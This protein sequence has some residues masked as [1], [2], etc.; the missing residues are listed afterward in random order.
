MKT[1]KKDLSGKIF[2]K[3]KV[4]ND[5]GLRSSQGFVRW[6][7][8]CACGTLTLVGSGSLLAGDIRSCGCLR[9]KQIKHGQTK[10]GKRTTEY[11]TWC[12]ILKRCYNKKCDKYFRYGGRGIFVDERWRNDF[13]SFFKD[14]GVKPTSKHTIERI[15]NNGPYSPENCK[16]ATQKEQNRNKKNNRLIKY[17]GKTLC[18]T[19]WAEKLGVTR[20]FLQSKIRYAQ[21][22][23]ISESV[24]IEKLHKEIS[25]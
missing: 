8:R 20:D 2:D 24:I 11:V 19:E 18:L 1:T 6:W 17:N 25:Q 9:G 13:A 7:C 21:G 14:M 5:S 22:K 3:L 4:L 10:N 12:N 15:D 23:N 16:W